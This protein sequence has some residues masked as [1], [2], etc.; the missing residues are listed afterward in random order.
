MK[1]RARGLKS[2]SDPLLWNMYVFF[3]E[4]EKVGHP[5]HIF[6][7]PLKIMSRPGHGPETHMYNSKYPKV[8]LRPFR[9]YTPR[10]L[11]INLYKQEYF[12]KL[13]Q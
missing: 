5:T 2:E 4:M 9:T 10:L 11:S 3:Y 12:F 7:T 1:F 13:V 6:S 8:V